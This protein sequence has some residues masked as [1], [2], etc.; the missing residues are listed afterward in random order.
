MS[1][2][3]LQFEDERLDSISEEEFQERLGRLRMKMLI[4][5]EGVWRSLVG[6]AKYGMDEQTQLAAQKVALAYTLG[7]PV[8]RTEVTQ[9]SGN[10]GPS[11]LPPL[12]ALSN[13]ELQAL[14]VI[15]NAQRR[16]ALA[17]GD[18]DK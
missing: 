8:Q 15:R 4:D 11:P 18:D 10:G 3:L 1:G 5:A 14:N 13:D 16:R 12:E 17:S 7:I 2:K 9:K 6:L